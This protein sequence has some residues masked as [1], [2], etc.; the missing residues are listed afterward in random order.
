M[1]FASKYL[2]FLVTVTSLLFIISGNMLIRAKRDSISLKSLPYSSDFSLHCHLIN[3]LARDFKQF[4]NT[5]N[6]TK[7]NNAFI[8]YSRKSSEETYHEKEI[9]G[10]LLLIL[11]CQSL[12][13]I[14][15]SHLKW[16]LDIYYQLGIIVFSLDMS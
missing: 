12:R 2:S 11:S 16:P 8:R 10:I 7:V 9:F 14:L 4:L 13:L 1:H 3:F 5:G 15:S 6:D